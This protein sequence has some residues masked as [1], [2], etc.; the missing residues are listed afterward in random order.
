VTRP[1]EPDLNAIRRGVDAVGRL[2]DG[3]LRIGPWGL[4]V[5]GLLSWIPGVGEAYSALAAAYLLV[6]GARARVP[7]GTLAA[8][9][10]L[11]GGRTLVTAIP[12]VGPLAADALTLHRWSARLI[13]RAIDRRIEARQGED[14][15]SAGRRAPTRLRFPRLATARGS[16]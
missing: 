12:L 14:F 15:T 9:A 1:R 5:D 13:V 11:M 16:R 4:G 10:A 6:Q 2:S 8:A 7:V 3:L